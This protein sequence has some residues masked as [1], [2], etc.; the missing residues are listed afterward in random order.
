MKAHTIFLGDSQHPLC[1]EGCAAAWADNNEDAD[2]DGDGYMQT[3]GFVAEEDA[4]EFEGHPCAHCATAIRA[5][6]L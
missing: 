5:P 6:K 2:H 1:S 3:A 4:A